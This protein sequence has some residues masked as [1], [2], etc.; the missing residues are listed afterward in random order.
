MSQ[1]WLFGVWVLVFGMVQCHESPETES[2]SYVDVKNLMQRVILL[3]E[4]LRMEKERN[5][6]LEEKVNSLVTNLEQTKRKFE[7]K[8]TS[9]EM[10]L[11]KHQDSETKS[12]LFDTHHSAENKTQKLKNDHK[13]FIDWQRPWYSLLKTHESNAGPEVR[14]RISSP[15]LQSMYSLFFNQ[16]MFYLSSFYINLRI[17]YF[18]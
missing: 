1:F 11:Q 6:E 7:D 4:S 17:H 16:D 8:C 9:L 3:E 5:D 10:K 14:E 15:N 13:P 12:G 2:L 18:N